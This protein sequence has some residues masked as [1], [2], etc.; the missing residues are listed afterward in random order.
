MGQGP[1]VSVAINRGIIKTYA[2]TEYEFGESSCGTLL[3]CF[4]ISGGGAGRGR[5][6]CSYQSDETAIIEADGFCINDIGNGMERTAFKTTGWG[7]AR[8]INVV[9]WGIAL[10]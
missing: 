2:V 4:S 1:S 7:E 3:E 6:S 5:C 8:L 10:R 9:A